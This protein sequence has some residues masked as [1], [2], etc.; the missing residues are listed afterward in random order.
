MHLSRSTW[1]RLLAALVASAGFVLLFGGVVRDSAFERPTAERG[2]PTPGS[3]LDFE[4][5]AYCK[6]SMTA[7]GTR[8]GRRVTGIA[9][10]DPDLLPLGS[11]VSINSRLPDYDGIY[12]VLDT[13][14]LI[15]GRVVDLYMWSCFEALDFGRQSIELRIL[16][17]GWDPTNTDP[18][19]IDEAFGEG[20]ESARRR[21]ADQPL[22]RP[23]PDP[24]PEAEA[25]AEAEAEPEPA[26]SITPDPVAAPD[27]GPGSD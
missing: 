12:T 17:Y 1:R 27:A 9:A 5:T 15:Q 8:V 22:P 3:R 19:M 10:A 7:T 23:E 24:E 14:P 2:V 13:G 6:G 16:R 20:E 21:G 11:V 18:A 25:E 26:Q 4:A